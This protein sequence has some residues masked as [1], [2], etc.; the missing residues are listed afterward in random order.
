M[1][2]VCVSA[3]LWSVP[4]AKTTQ[5]TPTTTTPLDGARDDYRCVPFLGKRRREDFKAARSDRI[6]KK[7]S[8]FAF[9]TLKPSAFDMRRLH[10][11]AETAP[12]LE[13]T[14]RKAK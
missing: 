9:D 2:D 14:N 4:M 6:F 11:Q 8:S 13:L 5:I 3:V 10:E 1:I 12:T 7:P